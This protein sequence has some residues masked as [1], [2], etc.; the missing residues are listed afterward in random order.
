[1]Q[2]DFAGKQSFTQG[3]DSFKHRMRLH[4]AQRIGKT[5]S[6]RACFD[7]GIADLDQKLKVGAGGI[8]RRVADFQ[9]QDCVHMQHALE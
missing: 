5:D 4:D 7:G 6:V 8:F 2:I 3:A 1:M 9:S